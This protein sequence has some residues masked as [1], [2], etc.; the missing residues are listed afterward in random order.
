[1]SYFARGDQIGDWTIARRIGRG[2]MGVVYAAQHELIGKR[3]AI[4]V[5]RSELRQDPSLVERFVHEARVVNQLT[6][7][8]IVDIFHIGWLD[9]GRVY[10]V[11]E[12]LMARTLAQ[13]LRDERYAPDRAIELI[14]RLC[15]PLAVA[16]AHRVVHRDLK[17]GNVFVLD[18]RVKLIDWGLCAFDDEPGPGTLVGTPRYAAPEQAQGRA[19]DGRA[20]IYA[21]GAIAYELLFGRVPFAYVEIGDLVR[22]HLHEAPPPPRDLWREIPVA[23]EEL[24]I[25]M[26]AKDPAH[27]PNVGQVQA[28]LAGLDPDELRA[29]RLAA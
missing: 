4:K 26:L 27:R 13:H 1:M 16:H 6:H 3:V 22:G 9:D 12:F 11:M 8:S 28:T 19:V 25:A 15:E 5:I 10:L 18:D 14:A 23:L 2:G 20:D 7:P 29:R 21:L 24:M 17:P